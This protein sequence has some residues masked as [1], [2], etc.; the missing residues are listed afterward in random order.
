[1]FL[2][3]LTLLLAIRPSS[4]QCL[5]NYEY[6]DYMTNQ[7]KPCAANCLTCFDTTTCVAC[8]EEYFLN[9]NNECQ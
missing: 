4:E 2:A 1:M 8:I 6:Y 9:S 7:C 3:F 5:S